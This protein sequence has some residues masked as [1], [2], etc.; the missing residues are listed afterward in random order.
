MNWAS[1]DIG[2]NEIPGV[3]LVGVLLGGLLLLA[4]IRA[5]FGRGGR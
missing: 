1:E 2:W 5:M 4:A 3:R